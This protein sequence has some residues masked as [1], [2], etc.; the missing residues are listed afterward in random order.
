MPQ[1]YEL[2]ND[3]P[4]AN[5]TRSGQIK[6][7]CLPAATD[8][9]VMESGVVSAP[10]AAMLPNKQRTLRTP[11]HQVISYAEIILEE[12][13][14]A[15][16][17]RLRA[18][19]AHVIQISDN[20]LKAIHAAA[21]QDGHPAVSGEDL[22]QQLLEQVSLISAEVDEVQQFAQSNLHRSFSS[23]LEKLSSA[24][25]SFREA[26]GQLSPDVVDAP[27]EMPPLPAMSPHASVAP[28]A[29]SP[30]ARSSPEPLHGLVL[31]VDDNEGNRDVLS[32]RLLRDGC[33]VLL[34]ESGRQALRMVQRYEFDVILLD[35]MMP[36]MD[37]YAV[38][39]ELKK[40]KRFCLIPII[41]ISAVDEIESVVRCIE[42]GA[43]DYLYKPFNPV[44]LRAR[45][46]ALLERNRLRREDAR[47]TEKLTQALAQ[48]KEASDRSQALLCNILPPSIAQELQTNGS[49][50]PRYFE[51]A[52]IVFTD[53]V[54]FT[55]LTEELP[56]QDLVYLLN[57]YFSAFDEIVQRYGLEK[58]KTIGDAYMFAGGLP[59][60]N[61]SHPVDAV[62][63][64]MEVV[65]VSEELAAMGLAQWK[66][67]VGIHTGPVAAGVVGMHKFAFD[68]WGDTVNVAS[69]MESHSEPDRINVSAT[70]YSRVKD[71]FSCQKRGL[72]KIKDG[73][74]LQMY[75]V[76][77]FATGVLD[78]SL[79]PG[80]AFQQRYRSYFQK[81]STLPAC[82]MPSVKTEGKS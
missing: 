79:S 54:D 65:Q 67:R 60:R 35:I 8:G 78:K 74:E 41:M 18:S 68:I 42:L 40:H 66:L 32:R 75:L 17:P 45:L 22:A 44:L 20:C 13:E 7:R 37:G 52:T 27:G 10:H 23:D 70:T 81:D 62:L 80:A 30:V 15:E 12:F 19:L 73:R 57:R 76:N 47:R 34:A 82:L 64:A 56:T 50:E 28:L 5:D 14:Q 33:E 49:V 59:T 71:F 1:S 11:L 69:R 58:L 3:S 48:L 46:R 24:I 36:D 39:S 2:E 21:P 51:D 26:I 61:P 53:F 6:T 55:L 4:N 25:R 31:V 29:S 63:A 72:V 43:D 77:T 9:S 16:D 38:L